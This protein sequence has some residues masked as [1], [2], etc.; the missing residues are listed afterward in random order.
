MFSDVGKKIKSVAEFVFVFQVLLSLIGGIVI[1]ANDDDMAG[2]GIL[3]I[4]VGSVIAWL[5]SLLIYAY[6]EIA[7]TNAQN[8]ENTRLIL[9]LLEERTLKKEVVPVEKAAVSSDTPKQPRKSDVKEGKKEAL[10]ENRQ[11]KSEN[12]MPAIISGDQKICPVCKTAQKNNRVV[13]W[14]CNQLFSN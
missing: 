13:C 12:P 6:G 3:V 10:D 2:L 4:I 1:I 9:Q 5:S 7:Q 14:H 8:E 11:E